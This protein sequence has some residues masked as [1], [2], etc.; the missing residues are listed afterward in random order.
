MASNQMRLWFSAFAH[1]ML[2]RLQ[3]IALPGTRLEK[4][5]IGTLRL[6]LFK[7]AARVKISVRRIRFE[8][9]EGCPIRMSSLRSGKIFRLGPRSA[10]HA[11]SSTE[12]VYPGESGM[13]HCVRATGIIKE[14]SIVRGKICALSSKQLKSMS[15]RRTMFTNTPKN[16]HC[17]PVGE[18]CGLKQP[19][20][21]HGNITWMKVADSRFYCA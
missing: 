7:I 20:P 4:G 10:Q 16:Y 11:S 5:T 21:V 9:A 19:V 18:Q 12:K 6:R 3:A 15:R 14:M 8:L 17:D 2:S 13:H 1:L